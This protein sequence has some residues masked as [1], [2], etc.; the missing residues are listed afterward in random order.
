M[1]FFRYISII[2]LI[3]ISSSV[4]AKTIIFD[5]EEYHLAFTQ[6]GYYLN[7]FILKGDNLDNWKKM[8]STRV[9]TGID[10]PKKYAQELANQIKTNYPKSPYEI[11]FN[12]KANIAIIDFFI[13]NDKVYEY[14]IFKII[15]ITINNI[16][17]IKIYQFAFRCYDE[18]SKEEQQTLEKNRHHWIDLVSKAE[19]PEFVDNE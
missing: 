19:V 15:P 1:L 11:V 2:I 3:S 10:N 5:E 4:Y 7:E 8:L 16:E 9:I 14:N 13:F 18:C 17:S 12:S 6:K